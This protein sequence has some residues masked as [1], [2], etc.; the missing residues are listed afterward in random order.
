LTLTKFLLI[1]KVLI[2]STSEEGFPVF[3]AFDPLT[4]EFLPSPQILEQIT[5]KLMG[6]VPDKDA[7]Y[8][9]NG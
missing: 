6:L 4:F 7:A 3:G 1:F 9:V 8:F 2:F 5:G